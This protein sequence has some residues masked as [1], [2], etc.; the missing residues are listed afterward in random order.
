MNHTPVLGRLDPRSKLMLQV[1]FV[2]AAYVHTNPR[3]LFLLTIVTIA[4]IWLCG[5]RILAVLDEFKFVAGFLAMAPFL[6]SLTVIHPYVIVSD[7]VEPALAAYRVLLIVLVSVVIARVMT[8]REAEAAIRWLLPGR[9]GRSM[10]TGVGLVY[11]FVPAMSA[12]ARR[13]RR[14]ITVRGGSARPV[15]R[16]IQLVGIVTLVRLLRRA[17]R[18]SRA[19][20][21]RCLAWNATVPSLRFT[22]KD[23]PALVAVFVLLAWS[24]GGIFH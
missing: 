4:I 24:I 9:M 6:A 16:R 15:S 1:A 14:A 18:V 5:Q 13:T 12:E 19:L 3:S 17:D 20:R 23:I 10:G 22:S 7:A 8:A 11:R 2:S 21:V